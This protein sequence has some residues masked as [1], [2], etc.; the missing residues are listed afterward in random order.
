M[1]FDRRSILR[2]M[3]G[4]GALLPAA[5]FMPNPVEAQ[6]GGGGGGGTQFYNFGPAFNLTEASDLLYMCDQL[7]PSGVPVPSGFALRWGQNAIYTTQQSVG[8]FGNVFSLWKSKSISNTFSLIVRGTVLTQA[9]VLEDLLS[10]LMNATGSVPGINWQFAAPSPGP[11]LIAPGQPA[12]VHAGFAVGAIYVSLG[13]NGELGLDPP[14][15]VLPAGSKIYIAGHS[16]GAAVA[17]LLSSLFHYDRM[18]Q[19]RNYSYKTYAFAQPKPGNDTYQSDF[20][21]VFSNNGFGFRVTNSLDFVPQ[22]PFT[23]EIPTDLNVAI[24]ALP[25]T[26]SSLLA[27]GAESQMVSS[28]ASTQMAKLQAAFLAVA[29]A[30]AAGRPPHNAPLPSTP[31]LPLPIIDSYNFV[32]AGRNWSLIGCPLPTTSPNATDILYQHHAITY[33][34]LMQ[35]AACPLPA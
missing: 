19:Q 21:S 9:S 10:L 22:L 28:V 29:R 15:P 1:T 11:T 20:E 31:I 32:N 8:P 25:P 3:L 33:Y 34:N 35:G 14:P 2:A 13:L 5:S 4:S 16:Q 23:I 6:A 18:M 27:K 17:T 12:G 24:T 30:K 7:N 26:L